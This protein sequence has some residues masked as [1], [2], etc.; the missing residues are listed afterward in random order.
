MRLRARLPLLALALLALA[1]FAVSTPA[2]SRENR[3]REN[4]AREI[5]AAKKR[6]Q[7]LLSEAEALIQAGRQ[8]QARRLL[9]Q[10]KELKSRLRSAESRS[11]A[12][13]ER[14]AAR[15]EK[16]FHGL[17]HHLE[18]AVHALRELDRG[19]QAE[20]LSALAK[21]LRQSLTRSS[22]E[23]DETRASPRRGREQLQRELNVFR[24][25]KAMFGEL[26]KKNL[27]EL[28]ERS[29]HARE[30]QLVDRRDRQAQKI[31]H[32]QPSV[33]NEIELLAYASQ[34]YEKHGD[35][36]KS[37]ALAK[38]AKQLAGRKNPKRKKEKKLTERQAAMQQ[39][40]YMRYSAGV[41]KKAKRL[42]A[43][44]SMSRAANALKLKL[45]GRRDE[46]AQ[47]VIKR[48][49]D[50]AAIARHFF[51]T[52]E[53]LQDQDDRGHAE[54]V[55]KMGR[56]FAAQA[57]RVARSARDR[58]RNQR[59]HRDEEEIEEVHEERGARGE[60]KQIH[61]LRR[62]VEELER[63]LKE[64]QEANKRKQRRRDSSIRLPSK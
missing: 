29:M 32:A 16:E 14:K 38:L 4:Q 54:A 51:M 52:A 44:E 50:R 60:D 1:A 27:V 35:G 9:E 23:L 10:A 25:A 33:G 13:R 37:A 43:A 2:Q 8:N 61:K 20:R 30:L 3:S 46:E 41:L 28:V 49:P 21:E 19:E 47:M 62:R 17:F 40:E 6:V 26:E 11:R 24:L 59:E 63:V 7:V 39:L 56:Q 5:E 12:G 64:L 58:R 48:A 31:M 15:G 22:R 34:M 53:I 45:D 57:E 18:G 42:D 36:E 55:A